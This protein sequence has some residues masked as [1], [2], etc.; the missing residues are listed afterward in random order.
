MSS[1]PQNKFTAPNISG[2]WR[3]WSSSQ[4]LVSSGISEITKLT[5]VIDIKQKNLFFNYRNK[6]LDFNRVGTFVKV[7]N[8]KPGIFNWFNNS[9]KH[10]WMASSVNNDDGATLNFYPYSYKNG[11]PTKM[12]GTNIVPGPLKSKSSIVYSVYYEKI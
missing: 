10:D 2:K 3:Y 1:Y 7:N 6:E 12:T 11:K 4:S 5:G 9:E 8:N